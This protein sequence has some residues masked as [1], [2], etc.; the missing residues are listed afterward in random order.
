MAEQELD[1]WATADKQ[2]AGKFSA[3]D[4]FNY[5]KALIT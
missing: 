3:G 4:L 5:V 2:F 1:V